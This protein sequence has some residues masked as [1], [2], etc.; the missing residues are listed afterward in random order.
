MGNSEKFCI[1][2]SCWPKRLGGAHEIPGGHDRLQ[3]SLLLDYAENVRRILMA[4]NLR[5]GLE[6]EGPHN[7]TES[8]KRTNTIAHLHA[9]RYC[10]R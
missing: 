5:S 2:L 9:E 6:P 1:L 10:K 3:A 4:G 8:I 7:T